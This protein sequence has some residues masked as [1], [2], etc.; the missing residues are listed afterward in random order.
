MLTF[1]N[2]LVESTKVI[3]VLNAMILRIISD[4]STAN[5]DMTGLYFQS[6]IW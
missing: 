6:V 5:H 4:A 2:S 1:S 3:T